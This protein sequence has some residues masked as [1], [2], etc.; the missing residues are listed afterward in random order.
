MRILSML[1]R[2][3]IKLVFENSCFKYPQWITHVRKYICC[4]FRFYMS[5]LY[6]VNFHN[7]N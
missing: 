3:A 2:K 4:T 6:Y 1:T 7:N 5:L